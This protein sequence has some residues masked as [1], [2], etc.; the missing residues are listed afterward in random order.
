MNNNDDKHC[1]FEDQNLLL[2]YP[3][4]DVW[5][6]N[7][8]SEPALSTILKHI[9]HLYMQ[10]F[11]II[12]LFLPNVTLALSYISQ[13]QIQPNKNITKIYISTTFQNIKTG[14]SIMYGSASTNMKKWS[15]MKRH[16]VS[17]G[18]FSLVSLLWG[19]YGILYIG[20]ALH[21]NGSVC[22]WRVRRVVWTF[23]HIYHIHEVNHLYVSANAKEGKN[24]WQ[25]FCHTHHKLKVSHQYGHGGEPPV[26]CYWQESCYKR[27]T[28]NQYGISHALVMIPW[29]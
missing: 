23:Y 5:G 13:I 18:G 9:R 12:L 1:H 25:T 4:S 17:F 19:S 20:M 27:H 21:L 28:E 10:V 15:L 6:H 11:Q 22:E 16:C 3:H 29:A 14:T 7:N 24:S 8:D 2:P 26:R